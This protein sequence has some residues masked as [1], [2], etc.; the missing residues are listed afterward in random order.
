MND[1]SVVSTK[2]VPATLGPSKDVS[3]VIR[4]AAEEAT[5]KV[6]EKIRPFDNVAREKNVAVMLLISI[7]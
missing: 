3:L 1:V 5:K 7:G 6:V 2:T 4:F